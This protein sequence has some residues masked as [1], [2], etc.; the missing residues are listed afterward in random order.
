MSW[1]YQA[2][3]LV[4]GDHAI[5]PEWALGVSMGVGGICGSYLGARLQRRLPEAA[6]RRLLGIV[7]LALA[8]RYAVQGAGVA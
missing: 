7:C 5:A 4:K 6:L 3:E 1:P 2:L 8:V